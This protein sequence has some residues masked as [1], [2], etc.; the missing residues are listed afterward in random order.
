MKKAHLII[1]LIYIICFSCNK[2]PEVKP[3]SFSEVSIEGAKIEYKQVEQRSKVGERKLGTFEPIW[4][5]AYYYKFEFGDAVIIPLKYTNKT[6][7]R[8]SSKETTVN[9]ETLNKLMAYLDNE[10][11]ITFKIIR[12]IPTEQFI[13]DTHYLT[14][15][16]PYSGSV[17]I[18]DLAENIEEGYIYDTGKLVSELIIDQKKLRST[19]GTYCPLVDYYVDCPPPSQSRMAN[20]SMPCGY[21]ISIPDCYNTGGGGSDPGYGG[22]G[23]GGSSGGNAGANALTS[24]LNLTPQE[25]SWLNSNQTISD[26][27]VTYIIMQDPFLQ[28]AAKTFAKE[29]IEILVSSNYQEPNYNI[30]NF[31]GNSDGLPFNWW[32][33]DSYLDTYFSL[34]PYDQFKKLTKAEKLLTTLFPGVAFVINQNKNTALNITQS[35]FPNFY[36]LNDKADAFRHAFFNAINAQASVFLLGGTGLIITLMFG[37]AHE[38]EVPPNLILEK[39]MD[40]FNNYK[41][42]FDSNFDLADSHATIKDKIM[43]LLNNGVLRYLSPIDYSQMGNSAFWDNPNTPVEGDG[44][45]GILGS[46]LLIPTNQ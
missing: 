44:H 40:L 8:Y 21:W 9:I 42:I 17:F 43:A 22:Y 25:N 10:G 1:I 12:L 30:S 14:K 33:D 3:A 27:I 26:K 46:T 37:K 32:N 6:F 23:G 5:N 45:H 19:S 20:N 28:D 7:M 31:P 4:E 2:S 15:K 16:A 29:L 35:S 36:Q 38:S 34:D 13:V 39:E 11:K 41:G 18:D 24:W